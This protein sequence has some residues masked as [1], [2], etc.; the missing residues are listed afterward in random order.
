MRE[1]FSFPRRERGVVLL[2]ALM[3]LVVLTLASIALVR[4]VDTTSLIAGNLAF[5]KSATISADAGVEAAFKYLQKVNE[6]S[7]AGYLEKSHI[8]EAYVAA[9]TNF[10]TALLTAKDWEKF[11]WE[12]IDTSGAPSAT[13][14]HHGDGPVCTLPTDAAGN[15]VS[16]TIQRL[17]LAEGP[18]DK[19]QCLRLGSTGGG[20]AEG[21]SS[22]GGT[23]IQSLGAADAGSDSKQ[24]YAY[25]VTARVSGPRNTTTYLQVVLAL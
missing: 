19:A 6:K 13:N 2:I 16:Y 7:P 4:S 9:T 1:N 8:D 18:F 10:S 15:T 25:R 5:Q 3:I 22:V 17:C 21:N 20:E 14:C 24:R 11:W 12:N 23:T